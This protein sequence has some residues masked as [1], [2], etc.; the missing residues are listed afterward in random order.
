VSTVLKPALR[1]L[2]RSPAFTAT[3]VLTLV[4]GLA[5]LT[6]IFSLVN[7]VLLRPLPYADPERL[8]SARHDLTA[9]SLPRANQTSATYFTYQKLART[10]DGIGVYQDASVNVSDPRGGTEPQ[11]I[12]AGYISATLIPVLGVTPLLGRNFTAE[13]DLPNGAEAVLISESLWRSRFGG[14]RNVLGHTLDVNGRTREIVGVMPDRFRFPTSNTQLWVPLRLDPN[15]AHPGGFSYDGIVRLT[16]GVTIEAAQR[17]FA[18]VL[19]RMV[20]LSPNMAPGVTTQM[21]LDQA[22]PVPV[23]IPLKE[24]VTGGIA[25]TLWIV[26]AAAALVLLVACA[27]VINLMLVR[28]DARQREFAVREAIGARRGRVLLH[29]FAEAALI[30]GGAGAI[31]LAVAAAALR[32]VARTGPESIPRLSEVAVDGATTAFAV[33]LAAAV[34]LVCSIVPALRIGG[35]QLPL[36]LRDGRSGT[37]SRVQQ[38]VRGA[39]V[40]GQIALALVA[41]GGSGLFI[42]SFLAL[43]AVRPGFEAQGVAT[44]WMSPT[45][46]RYPNDTAVVQFYSTVLERVAA[47]PGVSAAGISSRLPLLTAGMNQNPYFPEGDASYTDRIPPLQIFTTADAGYFRTMQIPL[48]AGRLFQ[49]LDQQRHD[50]AIISRATAIQFY[51]DSTGRAAVGRRFTDLPNGRMWT[52]IGVVG[53]ARDTALAA[54]P[55]QTVYFPQSP[56]PDDFSNQVRNT[57]ALVVR[58]AG[59]PSGV[60]SAVQ[61]IVQ[62]LDRDLP[63]YNVRPM[64]AVMQESMGQLSFTILLLG[65]AAVVTLLLGAVGLYGV[66]AYVVALRTRELGVRIALGATPRSIVAMLTSQGVLLTAAGI[67]AGV[68]VFLGAARSLRTL[69]FGVAP[70]DPLTLVL[71]SA[72]LVAVAALASWL[73]ARRSA[74][75]DPAEVLRAD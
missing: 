49:R 22:R 59:D 27:N 54:P 29:F 58:T 17:D 7:A 34:A 15:A 71:A 13:E 42:R 51:G 32:I 38:R 9:L 28:A 66:M 10:I 12:G 73:P 45:T 39:L 19:P 36:A 43:N 2:R 4:I 64:T 52:V 16:A 20:E 44:F 46:A 30:A 47:L 48:L 55:S 35:I 21:L 41:L 31:A 74:R 50:E 33:L 25:R 8:V 75:L 67:A 70:S 65:A 18:A 14:D 61:R 62:D 1:A 26:A 6:T 5:A 63:V 57:M 68:V 72:L 23:L 69:L 56:A 60:A 40:A 11:R 3:A 37:A 53:D 24:E